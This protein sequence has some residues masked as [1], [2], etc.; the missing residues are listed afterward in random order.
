MLLQYKHLNSG[1]LEAPDFIFDWLIFVIL[2]IFDSLDFYVVG[3]ILF[4]CVS[5]ADL[6][7]MMENPLSEDD[8]MLGFIFL[9]NEVFPFDGA[10]FIDW[11]TISDEFWFYD[12]CEF[13]L[14]TIFFSVCDLMLMSSFSC[15]NLSCF[16]MAGFWLKPAWLSPD[17]LKLKLSASDD[18]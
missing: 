8:C 11:F 5:L 10:T 15:L 6:S 3:V 18:L 2:D 17:L 7:L 16:R 14:Y 13:F 1:S 4:L 12:L 9:G